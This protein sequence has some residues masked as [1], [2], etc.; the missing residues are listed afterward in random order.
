VMMFEVETIVVKSI[1]TTT[2][3]EREETVAFLKRL[4]LVVLQSGLLTAKCNKR[5]LSEC[6]SI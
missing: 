6:Q 1:V 4:T 5:R 3:K 2:M